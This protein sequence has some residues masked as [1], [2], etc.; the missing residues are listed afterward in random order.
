[1]GGAQMYVRNKVLF[2]RKQGWKVDVITATRGEVVIEEL[3]Q[4]DK[5]MPELAFDIYL[6]SKKHQQ[7]VL[8]QLTDWIRDDNY[9]EIV[10]ESTCIS[11]CSW[12]EAVA[13][14]INA[15]NL[16]YLL[17]EDNEV[18]NKGMQDFFKFKHSR[19][20]LV[21]ITEHS[22]WAMFAPFSPISKQES[23]WLPAYC[24][25][26]EA[27]IDH[28]LLHAID[29]SKFTHLIGTVSRLDKPFILP[30]LSEF[31][32]YVRSYPQ[33]KFLYL[34]IGGAPDNSTV[35]SDIK[36]LFAQKAPN[37]ELIMVGYL[38]PVPTRLL[39]LCDVFVTSAGSGWLCQKSGVPTIAIDCND[40]KPIGIL[41]R[42]TTNA[43]F[44]ADDEP[45]LDFCQ[46]LDDVLV[47]AKYVRKESNYESELPDFSEHMVFLGN[48]SKFPNYYDMNS[49][50]VESL[51]DK[52]LKWALSIIGPSNY[53]KLGALKQNWKR[54][55]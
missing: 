14:L 18:L 34:L 29:K 7:N 43:L 46:L 50:K 17:Q 45:P 3:K 51:S 41:N 23:Y 27:D 48:S 53:L 10:I 40:F 5:S 24:N 20:E 30:L 33:K 55:K 31:C 15:K 1:M 21:G 39:E 32:K 2:L 16:C 38:F 13:R 22:L 49:I 52:K 19:N 47:N 35:D 25:N 11:E 12:A 8:S 42:T 4:F 6:Y 26:V 28:P 9:D 44:R 36:L 37:V 54:E